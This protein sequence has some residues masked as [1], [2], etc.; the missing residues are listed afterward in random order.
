MLSN[1][2]AEVFKH[3]VKFIYEGW[4]EVLSLVSETINSKTNLPLLKQTSSLGLT[5]KGLKVLIIFIWRS[6]RQNLLSGRTKIEIVSIKMI[7]KSKA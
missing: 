6:S 4:V 7:E 5:L 1:N 2:E 3:S